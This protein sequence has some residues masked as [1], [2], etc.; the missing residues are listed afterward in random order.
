MVRFHTVSAGFASLSLILLASP[1]QAKHGGDVCAAL[2][3][4]HASADLRV[5]FDIVDGRIHVQAR[6]NGKGP[7]R[8]AVDTGASGLGRADSSL[9]AALDLP[10]THTAHN[11]DGVKTVA[12]DVT[13]FNSLDLGGFSLRDLDVITRDYNRG[14]TPALSGIIA[15]D[16]FA[17]G[18]LLID[19]PARTLSFSKTNRLDPGQRDVLPYDRPFRVPVSIGKH[20]VE[21]NL[22]TGAN[23]SFIVPQALFDKIGGG[24]ARAA[25]DGTLSNTVIKTSTARMHG[26]FR[27]GAA[28]VSDVDVRISDRFPEL[29][30]G[31]HVLQGYAVL[32]D[33][34]T[35]HIALCPPARKK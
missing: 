5:P 30:V 1:V 3:A 32:I 22:D 25:S 14:A 31:A 2:P 9:V 35:K 19:Y 26:P 4:I 20:K 27:I 12:A 7:Y 17:D 10:I 24:K 11:S 18:L 8:F 21:G 13:R 15:R 23:V 16:F 34:R 29:L 33:Q 6:V 28:K